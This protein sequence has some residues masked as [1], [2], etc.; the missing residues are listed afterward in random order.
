[1][2][3]IIASLYLFFI[4]MFY[5]VYFLGLF[6]MLSKF[7]CNSYNLLFLVTRSNAAS[8]SSRYNYS[9]FPRKAYMWI[10]CS[11]CKSL[12]FLFVSRIMWAMISSQCLMGA[13]V[14]FCHLTSRTELSEFTPRSLSWFVL[15]LTP[16]VFLKS[17]ILPVP[18]FVF[19]VYSFI[20]QNKL[21]LYRLRP[22]QKHLRIF[23]WKCMVLRHRYMI[24]Q[25]RKNSVG[26]NF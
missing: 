22:Y 3:S 14:T 11:C 9:L 5:Q 1:M 23:R 10:P 18:W 15:H 8:T 16:Y 26:S 24:H 21:T 19:Q 12:F 17:L 13:S 2:H 25:R 4:F 6:Y 7:I 20:S